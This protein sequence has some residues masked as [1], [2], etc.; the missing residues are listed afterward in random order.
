MVLRKLKIVKV[1]F[2]NIRGING[3][4][5]QK[6]IRSFIGQH[7]C[8]SFGIVETK[9]VFAKTDQ[10]R[11]VV[12]PRWQPLNNAISVCSRIWLHRDS[13]SQCMSC[14]YMSNL[15]TLRLLVMSSE[16][17]FDGNLWI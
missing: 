13:S 6:A 1:A 2:W 14:S 7:K 3:T 16:V 5:K 4:N 12:C 8:K 17:L 9:T 15:Y 10:I 11:Q